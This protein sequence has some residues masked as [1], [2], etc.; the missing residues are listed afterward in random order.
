MTF[1]YLWH[2][3]HGTSHCKHTVPP[4]HR[5]PFFLTTSLLKLLHPPRLDEYIVCLHA[6]KTK[7][8]PIRLRQVTSSEYLPCLLWHLHPVSILRYLL[9]LLMPP[10]LGFNSPSSHTPWRPMSRD[11]FL[12]FH[13][14]NLGRHVQST[15]IHWSGVSGFTHFFIQQFWAETKRVS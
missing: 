9:Q 8:Y 6:A 11:A 10:G 15:Q 14:C 12:P 1:P 2:L 13:Q 4:P 3:F 5:I 7:C